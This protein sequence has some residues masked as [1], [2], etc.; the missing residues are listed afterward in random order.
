M[1]IIMLFGLGVVTGLAIAFI[2]LVATLRHLVNN[3]DRWLK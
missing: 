1:T 3:L 2:A